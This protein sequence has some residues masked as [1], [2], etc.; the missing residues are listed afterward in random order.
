MAQSVEPACTSRCSVHW[1]SQL[2]EPS[3]EQ[4]LPLQFALQPALQSV[5][6]SPLHGK[7]VGV[8]VHA[9][10]QLVSKGFVQVV[11]AATLHWV[12]QVVV[13]STGVR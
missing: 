12:E 13:K 9:V 3:A 2:A 1:V 6:Q 10:L 4:P 5:V 7:V 8:V 11:D